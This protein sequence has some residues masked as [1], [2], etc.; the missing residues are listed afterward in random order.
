MKNIAHTPDI[1]W[2]GTLKGLRNAAYPVAAAL[3]AGSLITGC[4]GLGG[5]AA[6]MHY[7]C[8]QGVEFSV[9]FVDDTAIL[10]GSRGH[11]LLQRDAGGQGPRQAFYSNPRMRAEFGLGSSGKE[12]IV[13][14]PLLPL[15]L[16]C[17]RG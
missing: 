10:D 9:K 14:Y 3:A 4:A 5:N 17:V 11:D 15:M 13:R 2:A 16:R 1:D 8:E 12:A 7:R 6:Q